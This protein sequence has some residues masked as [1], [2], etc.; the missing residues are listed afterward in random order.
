MTSRYKSTSEASTFTSTI[1]QYFSTHMTIALFSRS[2]STTDK[3]SLHSI[4]STYSSSQPSNH[5]SPPRFPRLTPIRESPQII[6]QS[7][8][9]SI[10]SSSS[11]QKHFPKCKSYRSISVRS[12]R[13]FQ[14][15]H[16]LSFRQLAYLRADGA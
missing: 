3:T 9:S 13:N 5:V 6:S 4:S 7:L 10:S 11:R 12:R 1:S 2:S 14:A 16:R 15:T 8:Y